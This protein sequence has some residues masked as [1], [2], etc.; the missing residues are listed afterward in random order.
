MRD[1]ELDITNA[2]KY[3]AVAEKMR[4]ER[5]NMKEDEEVRITLVT[6]SGK[7]IKLA[8]EGP[9][10]WIKGYY[11]KISDTSPEKSYKFRDEENYTAK[12]KGSCLNYCVIDKIMEGFF[13]KLENLKNGMKNSQ[14]LNDPSYSTKEIIDD[15]YVLSIFV[16]SEMIRNEIFEKVYFSDACADITWTQLKVFF[17]NWASTARV[18]ANNQPTKYIPC[19]RADKID[20]YINNPNFGWSDNN[21]AMLAEIKKRLR[22][23]TN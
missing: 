1:Y 3:H 11:L 21:K 12:D 4:E 22:Q 20:D 16:A 10:F 15:V 8:A 2:G 7:K 5:V 14:D 6:S 19:I 13:D 18:M 17:S 9:N 23:N